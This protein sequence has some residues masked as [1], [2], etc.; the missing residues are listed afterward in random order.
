MFLLHDGRLPGPADERAGQRPARVAVRDANRNPRPS[1]GWRT[2]AERAGAAR[3]LHAASAAPSGRSASHRMAARWWGV[4]RLRGRRCA[5]AAPAGS[6]RSAP[7]VVAG[8]RPPDPTPASPLRP[9]PQAAQGILCFRHCSGSGAGPCYVC[10]GPHPSQTQRQ[11]SKAL[12]KARSARPRW[13][14]AFFS[15][16]LNSAKVLLNGSYQKTGS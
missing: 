7:D 11:V 1:A 2:G 6:R 16:R 12:R 14:T 8:N 4:T 3:P 13:L 10:R 5:V 9:A 15:S